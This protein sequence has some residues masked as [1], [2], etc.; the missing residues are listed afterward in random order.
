[1]PIFMSA[2][3]S[4]P[5]PIQAAPGQVITLYIS[6]TKTARM[7]GDCDDNE[8]GGMGTLRAGSNQSASAVMTLLAKSVA[9]LS[10]GSPGRNGFGR[11]R[12]WHPA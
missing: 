7:L 11:T 8:V 10:P 4:T 1:M 3:Y 6:G 2:G 12:N 9:R 5:T